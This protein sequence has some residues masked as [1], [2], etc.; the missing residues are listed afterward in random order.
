MRIE[1]M[2]LRYEGSVIPLYYISLFG[3]RDWNQ[4]NDI[5]VTSEV[6]YQLSYTG[7]LVSLT[8]SESVT[9]LRKERVLL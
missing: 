5:L 4:T 6:L 1:L 2:C 9:S 3:A 7:L 8:E